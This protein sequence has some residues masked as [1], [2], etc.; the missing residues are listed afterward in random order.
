MTA[1]K[2]KPLVDFGIQ[3]GLSQELIEELVPLGK[4]LNIK[5]YENLIEV[6][7]KANSTF[8]VLKGGFI[9]QHYDEQT[10]AFKTVQFHLTDYQP[11]ITV[12]DSYFENKRSNN[13]IKAFTNSDVLAFNRSD[14]DSF[15]NNN[16]EFTRFYFK[17]LIQ[18]LI[19]E[20]QFKTNLICLTPEQVYKYII[21][22]YPQISQKVP[23]KYIAEFLGIT[24]QW[25]SKLKSR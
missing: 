16:I 15:L 10:E 14:L 9:N 1:T 20:N 11:F 21:H 19:S 8:F 22:N 4:L 3:C 5:T 25:L 17:M 13:Q 18:L 12:L 24:P 6:G 2:L 23:S 7:G